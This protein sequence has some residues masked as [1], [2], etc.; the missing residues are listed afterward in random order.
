MRYL[1][2]KRSTSLFLMKQF[3]AVCLLLSM[4]GCKVSQ[5]ESTSR[6]LNRD[7]DLVRSPYQYKVSEDETALLMVLR[8]MPV[9]E[10]AAD[11]VL[12]ADIEKAIAG[13]LGSHPTI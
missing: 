5:I 2:D 8:K 7:L 1:G 13:K 3:I 11:S 10:T 6:T 9:G 4:C 12:R